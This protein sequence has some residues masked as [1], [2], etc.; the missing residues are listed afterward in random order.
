MDAPPTRH[1]QVLIVGG[2]AAGITVAS[3]LRRRRPE[4]DVAILEPSADHWYQPGWT[5]VGGGLMAIERTR[6]DE[7]GLIPP[8]VTWIRS[9]ATAFAPERHRVRTGAGEDIGY[10]ALVVA[11]GLQCRWERIPGLAEALGHHGVCSNYSPRWAPATWRAIREF[12]GGTAVFTVPDTPIKCGGAPQK[13]M[14]LA[15]DQFRRRSGVGVNSRVIFCTAGRSLFSVPAYARVMEEVVRRRGIEVRFGW[16]LK[17]VRGSGQVAVF[18][19]TGADGAVHTEELPFDLLH[20]VP[21][22]TAPEVVAA[23]PLAIQGPGGW[24]EVDPLTTQHRRHPAVFALGDVAGLPTSKTAGAARGAAPVT[25]ANL[26]AFLDGQPLSARYDG[27]TV[28]PLITGYGS[29]VMLE[30]DYRRR[31]VSSF[32]VDPTR[33]R[34]SMW[35]LKTRVLPWLYWNRMLPGHPHEGRWLQPLAPL[36]HALRL[37]YREPPGG[38]PAGEPPGDAAAGCL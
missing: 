23:S 22:M 34:W 15:D 38:D 10:D 14:Y 37:D 2:G 1:H 9:A 6:R 13:V 28:C 25:A 29:V 16:N 21:P 18:E 24:V 35:L 30:F 33:E 31:P 19:V 36:V 7:A 5:L 11:T 8:G 3:I 20:A 12:R 17:E 27:Y 32:L 4:L 26:L